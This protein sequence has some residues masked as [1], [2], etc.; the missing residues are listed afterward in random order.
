M[1]ERDIEKALV[2][3]VKALGGIAYKFT[4]PANRSVPDRICL[5]PEG[6]LVFVECK[7]PGGKVTDNQLRVHE[8]IKALGHDVRIVDSIEQVNLFPNIA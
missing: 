7:R 2:K 1:L 5:L 4:S 8:K 3:R 6:R